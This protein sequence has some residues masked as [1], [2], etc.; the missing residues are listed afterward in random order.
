[1]WDTEAEWRLRSAW[2][3]SKNLSPKDI[4]GWQ[5]HTFTG[6]TVYYLRVLQDTEDWLRHSLM[7]GLNNYWILRLE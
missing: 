3:Y 5:A 6:I 1:M 4:S 2:G 7:R